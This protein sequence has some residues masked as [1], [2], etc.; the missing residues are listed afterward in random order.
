MKTYLD[1]TKA[2]VVSNDNRKVFSLSFLFK[3]VMA[4]L[5][6]IIAFAMAAK[7]QCVAPTMSFHSPVLTS[8]TDGQ[9]GAVYRFADVMPGVDADI[10]I[11]GITGGAT[12][13]NIDDSTGIGY[14]DAFQPYVGAAP[15]DTSYI[16]W[17]ITFKVGGTDTDTALACLAVTGVDVDGDAVALQEFIEAATPGSIAVD[18]Y[19]ILQV[20]F[21]GI[22]SKAISLVDNIPLI[23]TAHR[24]AM[25]QMNFTN[26]STLLYRNGAISTY[27]SEE[28]RQTCIYFKP[29]FDTYMMILPV[30]IIS[31]TARPDGKEVMLNWS[32]TNEKD[33]K[34]YTVQKSTDGFHWKNINSIPVGT[35]SATNNYFV[36]DAEKNTTVCYYRLKQTD[37]NNR[38][39]YSKI[40]KVNP[41]TVSA[42]SFSNN[43]VVNTVINLQ[44]AAPA[45]DAYTIQVYS[46]NGNLVKQQQDK[47]YAGF[48]TADIQLPASLSA[49]IYL[50]A[51]KNNK[52]QLIYN[53]KI[54]RN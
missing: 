35:N 23:D 12:L 20:S 2:S 44:V 10:E 34:N 30:K 39:T 54:I 49:G 46:M 41:G 15:N 40:V 21:D 36:A 5:L 52:G 24:E 38:A 16:D 19:T 7:A 26:I 13:Y 27:G 18:P 22:R 53:S 28:I 48:N 43:T 14:Y 25:F 29:F 6:L 51:V 4:I 11:V 8:G 17:K 31:F 33:T 45:S 32:A 42:A 37:I 50:L 9:V 1:H 3:I 47:I